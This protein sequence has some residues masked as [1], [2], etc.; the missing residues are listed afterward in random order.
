MAKAVAANGNDVHVICHTPESDQELG[1]CDGADGHLTIHTIRPA[2]T[3]RHGFFPSALQQLMY[4]ISMVW[5]G[6]R[7]IRSNKIELIHANTLS[8]AIAGSVLTLIYR[9]P[10]MNTIHHVYSI[11]SKQL[12]SRWSTLSEKRN[13]MAIKLAGM[14][15]LIYEKILVSL[16]SATI[17]SVS[18]ASALDLVEFGY[19][20]RID[21]IPNG[22]DFKRYD[23]FLKSIEYLPY[24]L[25]IGR[26]V[27]HKNLDVAIEGFAE[28]VRLLPNAR[29]VITGDGPMREKW[30]R[31]ITSHGLATS[32]E[33]MGYVSEEEKT[34]LLSKCSALIFPSLI[35]GFGLVILEAFALRKPV[36]VSDAGPAGELV[37]NGID[38]FII[39]SAS[40]EEWAERM[41]SLLLDKSLC[42]TMGNKGRI[43]A[44]KA[45]DI[46]D[47]AKRLE[48]LYYDIFSG[49]VKSSSDD[50]Y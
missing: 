30:E 24:L 4:V 2:L 21:I 42:Q 20:G 3:P 50:A 35:E 26:L 13:S 40:S 12:C 14:P 6:S 47:I 36:L 5:N 32:V 22:L 28:V 8:P 7:V 11:R 41:I 34:F 46:G 15:R 48:S 19:K 27:E 9:I 18:N 49:T 37:R 45:F 29:L 44:E 39:P 43:R 10:V 25:F 38:G 16:P 23:S 17:H 1:Q 31:K 33:F